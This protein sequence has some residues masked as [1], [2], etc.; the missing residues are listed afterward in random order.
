MNFIGRRKPI[1]SLTFEYYG[2]ALWD[3]CQGLSIIL[4]YISCFIGVCSKS[5][6]HFS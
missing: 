4:A 6:H 5:G 1:A 2:S 3:F